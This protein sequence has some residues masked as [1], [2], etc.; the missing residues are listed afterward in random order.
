MI[1]NSPKVFNVMYRPAQ[2]N[3]AENVNN[4]IYNYVIQTDEHFENLA[5]KEKFAGITGK[6]VKT[7]EY[8]RF[9]FDRI[10]AM[11][12]MPHWSWHSSC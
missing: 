6:D 4:E 10:V 3:G 12:A 5:R 11:N 2:H 9:R 1:D 8:K 7:G